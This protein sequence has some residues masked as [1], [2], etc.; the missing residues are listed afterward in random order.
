MFAATHSFLCRF[1]KDYYS[2]ALIMLAGLWAAAT[3]RTY[4]IGSLSHMG[5]GFFP[6]ALG[7]VLALI[8]VGIAF[9]AS[10][11]TR[12]LA[13]HDAT[14]LLPD[15]RGAICIV[16]GMVAFV[17]L[18]EYGGLLPASFAVAFI[19]AL[20]DRQNSVLSAAILAVC[21]CVISV[22]VF[23]WALRLQLPLFAWGE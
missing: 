4:E 8:G 13:L 7:I 18:G 9:S 12:Q 19:A 10:Y 11:G 23:W 14:P 21:I 16:S 2:G 22:V 3:G 20:G 6:M 15:W 1:D 17:V 5:P